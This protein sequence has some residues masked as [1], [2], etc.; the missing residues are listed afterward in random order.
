MLEVDQIRKIYPGTTKVVLDGITMS[1]QRNEF[2]SL[3][4]P[5]GCGKTTLL[6]IIGGLLHPTEGEV[7]LDG[8]P[9]LGPSKDKAIV[10]QHFNLFPWR[11]VYG[12]A[13]YGIEAH[14]GHSREER[15]ER[16]MRYLRLVGLE[17]WR[18][19]YPS[20]I[21]GGMQQR[22]GLAR[23]LAVEPKLLLMD[24]PFGALDALTRE[25]L[26]RQ[27]EQLYN[28]QEMTILFVT[29]SIDEALFLSD[30]ILVMGSN[31]GRIIKEFEVES[32]RPR[33]PDKLRTDSAAVEMRKEIW[34]LLEAETSATSVTES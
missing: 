7:R 10:F 13:S 15:E 31:P 6:R 17:E 16:V 22:V 8:L 33:D 25:R 24:E 26:Q 20:Q 1:Q 29:H 30:R 14:G 18:D 4:G 11:T 12:N 23:A 5:S 21:S 2:V 34:A 3:L 28:L 9:S 27:L 19:H 32:P